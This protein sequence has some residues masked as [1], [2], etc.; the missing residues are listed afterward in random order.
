VNL[1]NKTLIVFP[2]TTKMTIHNVV[3]GIVNMTNH[4]ILNSPLPVQHSKRKG[5]FICDF[6]N[7][8]PKSDIVSMEHPFYT[9][10]TKPD[11][12]IRCY[13]HNGNSLTITPSI[14]GLAT[15]HDKDVL[16]YC[17]SQLMTGMNKGKTPNRVVR[18]KA[19][20][21]LMTTNR[22]R[23][24]ESYKRLEK[25]FSR[26]TGTLIETN[27]KT[28]GTKINKKF[29]ILESVK[30]IY[31][32]PETKRMVELEVTL[33]EWLYN[34][35]LGKEVLSINPDYFKLRKPIERRIYEIA[36]KHCGQQEQW[37]IGIKNLHKKVGSVATLGK[38][39]FT[40]NHIIKHNHLPDY[41]LGLQGNNVIF[42]HHIKQASTP[43]VQPEHNSFYLK[44]QTME[45]AKKIVGKTY[46][47]YA[48]EQEWKDW[49]KGSGEP[50]LKSPD[51][52]FINFCKKRMEP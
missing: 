19:H 30:T 31:N 18:F 40:L 3:L 16:I 45:N 14:L 42:F 28:N 39:K 38:F 44:P 8:I 10:S 7:V 32:S 41:S 47:I 49:W 33:S 20:D 23:G 11:T 12:K 9:L 21:L 15:I 27:I 29:H 36:R 48:L 2:K 37:V 35:V 26:L 13:E 5:W 6:G 24:G 25:A 22:P 52:A 50:E 17:I 43:D 46:D 51:G 4:K 1:R 34:S